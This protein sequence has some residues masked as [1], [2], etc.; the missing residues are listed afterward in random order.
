VPVNRQAVER[1]AAQLDFS[2]LR[3]DQCGGRGRFR[4]RA[5]HNCDGLG[6]LWYSKPLTVEEPVAL[7]NIYSAVQVLELARRRGLT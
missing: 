5:C 1:I 7:S 6:T 3:C 2:T 4:G